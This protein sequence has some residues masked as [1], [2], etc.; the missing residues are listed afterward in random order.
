MV[1]TVA[2]IVA[3]AMSTQVQYGS[4]HK[5]S[6]ATIFLFFLLILLYIKENDHIGKK[7]NSKKNVYMLNQFYYY[8]DLLKIRVG[9]AC[10]TK[11]V[12]FYNQ[13]VPVN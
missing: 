6:H 9:W 3:N 13:S 5:M 11:V 4:N 10:K 12:L 2:V 1:K 8:S 7:A